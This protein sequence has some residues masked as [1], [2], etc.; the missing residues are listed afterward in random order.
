MTPDSLGK[1]TRERIHVSV[2]R[3]NHS[4]GNYGSESVSQPASLVDKVSLGSSKHFKCNVHKFMGL[5]IA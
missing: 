3:K 4:S 5:C 1:W 2:V